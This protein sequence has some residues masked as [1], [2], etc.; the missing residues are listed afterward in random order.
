[1]IHHEE[2][3]GRLI[4]DILTQTP[5][6]K[7]TSQHVGTST[8]RNGGKNNAKNNGLRQSM[9]EKTGIHDLL[10]NSA[11]ENAKDLSTK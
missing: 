9:E 5:E 11:T 2:A 3:T 10:L 1:M 7:D 6:A 8:L 4:L